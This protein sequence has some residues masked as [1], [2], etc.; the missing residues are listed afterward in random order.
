MTLSQRMSDLRE[1]TGIL[2]SATNW[3]SLLLARSHSLYLHSTIPACSYDLAREGVSTTNLDGPSATFALLPE[4]SP[5]ILA[6][7]TVDLESV[8]LKHISDVPARVRLPCDRCLQGIRKRGR[9][10]VEVGWKW[11]LARC[12]RKKLPGVLFANKCL[13]RYIRRQ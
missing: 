10:G 11:G 8:T 6:N 5:V 7:G 12:R 1:T 2:P 9:S 3:L 4:P 13:E